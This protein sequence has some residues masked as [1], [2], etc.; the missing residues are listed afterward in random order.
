MRVAKEP[1]EPVLF[2]E[3]L[4]LPPLPYRPFGAYEAADHPIFFGREEETLRGALLIDQAE[5]RCVLLHGSPGV[6]KTSYLQAGLLP[7][8]E[9]DSVGYRVLR[10]RSPLDGPIAEKDYPPLILRATND[11]AGQF[12]DALSVFCAQPYTYTTPAGTQVTIDLPGILHAAAAGKSLP[13]TTSTSSTAI[14]P[15]EGATAITALAPAADADDTS[16]QD[17]W[18]A[19]R[20]DKALLATV[21]DAITKALP[22]ELIIA[23][24]QGEELLTLVESPKERERRHKAL[25]ML[26]A[27]AGGAA[28]CKIIF[29]LRTQ[30]L[31]QLISLFPGAATPADWQSFYLKPFDEPEL[32]DALVWPTSR[33]EILGSSEVPSHKY[34]FAFED[35]L[36]PQI[37]SD[38]VEAAQ[39]HQSSPLAV[40]HAIGALLYR[41]QVIGKKQSI[42]S[43]AD[44]KEVGGV[45]KAPM[46]YLED[47]IDRL[48]L[49]KASQR[50]MRRLIA[51]LY[52]SH[53]DGTLSR[54][55]VPADDLK[56]YWVGSPE[57]VEPIV[58]KAADEEGLF[59]IQQLLI[60]GQ[61]DVY[62]SLAQDSLATL[63][64]EIDDEV[65]L[66]AFGRT[67]IIDTLWIMIPVAFLAAAMAFFFTRNFLSSAS[68]EEVI[69][70]VRA[71]VTEEAEKL[72]KTQIKVSYAERFRRQLYYGQIARADQALRAGNPL[73]ARQI[74]L[75]QPAARTFNEEGDQE[76]NFAELRGFEWHY[77]WKQL[78]G[79]R[80]ELQ[81][82]RGIVR[83]VAVAPDGTRAASAGPRTNLRE[84]DGTV[85][86]WNLQTGKLIAR[87][88]DSEADVHA[89]AF[90]RD[91]KTLAAGGADKLIRLYDVSKLKDDEMAVI[92]QPANTLKGHDGAIHALA[93]GSDGD[94]LASA[95]ADKAVLLWKVSAAK[96]QTL[97][98]H[99][100]PVNALAF[101]T[102]GKT[103]ASGSADGA[104]V[105][106]DA[107]T[108]KKRD[109]IKN[110]FQAVAALAISADGKTLAAGGSEAKFG[111]DLGL[112]RLFSLADLKEARA[113]PHG[114]GVNAVA[115]SSDG[116]VFSGGQD[117]VV[118]Q[119][120][121][122][123]GKE[124]HY[125]LGHYGAITALAVAKEDAALVSA[126]FDGKVKVWNPAQSSGLDIIQA[127]DDW[128]QCIALDKKNNLLASGCRDGSIKLWNPADGKLLL[129]VADL[130]AAVTALAFS[131]H[132]D[133]TLLAAATRD[134]QNKGDIKIWQIDLGPKDGLK[135]ALK[136]T[137][138]GH[139]KGVTC[140]AFSPTD[141]NAEL[142]ASGSA[143]HLVKLWDANT[144]KELRSHDRHKDEVRCVAFAADGRSYAS[145]GKDRRV[146]VCSIDH[147]DE[148]DAFA[149]VQLGSVEAIAVT[150]LPV[151]S[152]L[153]RGVK[154]GFMIG[155]SDHSVS[156]WV[157]DTNERGQKEPQQ[158]RYF[159]AH[160]QTVSSVLFNDRGFGLTVS[161]GW[162]GAIKLYDLDHD[163]FTLTGHDG[164]VRGV[165]MA[166]DQSFLAS[167]GN[168]GTIRF[169]RAAPSEAKKAENR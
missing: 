91:G 101:A 95:G 148:I 23:V 50:A 117:H 88:F 4:P 98:E 137:L 150:A 41:K 25:E 84:D 18:V 128:V 146:C 158:K 125:W 61:S 20:D 167:C 31:G 17:L 163:R 35:G 93:F 165:A 105:V 161:A 12:A 81:G 112:V 71:Q 139:T 54:D 8:L 14:Q 122:K 168:D 3:E 145:G 83:A 43:A 78:H 140:L 46:T 86:V 51:K 109:A 64:R 66:Q 133:K 10:D 42:L 72:I 119:W 162:D 157:I 49:L 44:L 169:W 155:G 156:I 38:A 90:A 141:D 126:S 65:E 70:K 131:N 106:W 97:S 58:N 110:R 99:Q 76:V 16:L 160:R 29:T 116:N 1:A 130:K 85:R 152:E 136:H 68:E 89:V 26:A 13:I 107:T 53:A 33:D 47:A 30:A 153:G 22:F 57:P 40:I 32:L 59:E 134:D 27:L 77:L 123:T 94:T 100:A 82:H 103:L 104:I 114:A 102:D 19:L 113:I 129:K 69:K 164:P 34:G 74:L 60:G 75:E 28:R 159:H 79:E 118:R 52:T 2:G 151:V 132:K 24:D 55:L 143:D 124:T 144:G 56:S 9:Q 166:A 37:V 73:R 5:T 149:D 63:G 62:V 45:K 92:N 108:A 39:A 96:S 7:F 138:G 135:A 142:L 36:A 120:D 80:F 87:I 154:P 48:K 147:K 121:I 127:H 115:V 67:K 6:G 15:Q 21:L 11:L 111:T